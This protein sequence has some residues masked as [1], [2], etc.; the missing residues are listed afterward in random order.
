M[1]VNT[2]L[3]VLDN[4]ATTYPLCNTI[5]NVLYVKK[6][7]LYWIYMYCGKYNILQDGLHW[8]L[9]TNDLQF[10]P[11]FSFTSPI[12]GKIGVSWSFYNHICM[13]LSFNNRL[14][15]IIVLKII[16]FIFFEDEITKFA[17]N[18]VDFTN[19]SQNV[20]KNRKLFHS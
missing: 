11:N 18:R 3:N 13:K 17:L 4:T 15:K 2:D 7:F 14:I 8:Q 20:N 1:F 19:L 16:P 10:G 9:V 5:R 12:C 6:Y